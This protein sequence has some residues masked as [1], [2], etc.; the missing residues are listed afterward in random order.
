MFDKS[1]LG[2]ALI[3]LRGSRPQRL[4]ARLAGVPTGTWCQWEKGKRQPRD[5][6]IEK[7]LEGLDCT[8]DDLLFE[9]WRIQTE[10]FK[11]RGSEVSEHAALYG[12]NSLLRRADDL[13]ELD[14]GRIPDP[15]GAALRRM[16]D[17]IATICAQV[18]PLISECEALIYALNRNRRS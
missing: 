10:R 12:E 11:V 2:E 16:R 18:E 8:M 5:S 15:A 4:I 9:I 1:L 17:I 13:M 6:Q 3:R 14:L 7:I